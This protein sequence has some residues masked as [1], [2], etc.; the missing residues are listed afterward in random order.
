VSLA[1][2]E[3]RLVEHADFAQ[4]N[5]RLDALRSAGALISEVQR[6]GRDLEASF[7]AAVSGPGQPPGDAGPPPPEPPRTAPDPLRGLR[8]TAR[9][10]R[11]I[12]ADLASRKAGWFGLA[13]ALLVLAL[14]F[15]G[16][17]NE[18]VGGA[19]A[20]VRQFG[21]P[22]GIADPATLAHWVGRWA[23]TFVYWALLPGTVVIAALFAPPLLDPRRTILLLAQPVSRGDLACA[24]YLTV[25]LLGLVEHAFLV[26]LLFGGL[27]WLGMEVSPLFLALV[28]P[29]LLGFAA[30]YAI[31]LAAAYGVRSGL[32][33]G[34]A[35]FG[36][37]LAAVLTQHRAALAAL[38][39]R[40]AA[41]GDQAARLGGGDAPQLAPFALTAAWA[42]AL[43]ILVLVMARR[44]EQ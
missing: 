43:F 30:L 28:A 15:W 23:A 19:A 44:S 33:S 35:A 18:V 14:F 39:P 21:G 20:A 2:G 22:G 41:L 31:A 13:L 25:C 5:A 37:F 3:T 38:L 6:V 34:A 27:R 29:L 12:V 10:A 16:V 42:A 1:G 8:A 40:V 11:E 32:A 24:L 26:A 36:V 17:R 4:L 7:E 9:L